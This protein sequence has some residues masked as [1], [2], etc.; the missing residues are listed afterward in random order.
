[1]TARDVE[2][3]PAESVDLPWVADLVRASFD[4]ALL[5]YLVAARSGIVDWWQTVL[6][7][8]GSFPTSRFL[9]ALADDGERLGYAELKRTDDTTGFL[10][11]VAVEPAARGRRVAVDL[12]AAYLRSEP[13]VAAME[14]DV[15]ETNGPARRLY[16]RLGFEET[17]RTAWWGAPLEPGAARDDVAVSDLHAVLARH[18]AYG[19]TD[20]VVDPDGAATRFGVLG[21]DV[22]RCFTAESFG[23]IDGHAA[24][25][26]LFPRL[27]QRFAVLP[28]GV[29]LPGATPLVQSLRLRSLRVVDLREDA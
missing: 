9:V 6:D 29:Q 24:M 4:D 16:D 23:D 12:L 18:R 21:D 17:A 7:H 2:V 1:M 27:A 5:P 20:A 28:A 25:R 22:L 15:F 13:D 8:P 19:F 3:R 26:H 11:Y 10:S 14:L